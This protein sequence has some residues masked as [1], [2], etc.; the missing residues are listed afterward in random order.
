MVDSIETFNFAQERA[1]H[2][3]KLYEILHDTRQRNVR[4]DWS[5]SFK[6]LMRWPAREEFVRVDG[7]NRQSM[8]IL[9]SELG[10][11]RSDFQHSYVSELLRSSLTSSISAMDLYFHDIIVGYSWTLLSRAEGDVPKE[12]QKIKIP[13]L[14]TK[15]AIKQ[16]KSSPN[17][18]PSLKLKTE[19]QK[20][21]HRD[22]FQSPSGVER[23]FKILGVQDCWGKIALK[24]SL[25]RNEIIANLKA[26]TGRRNQIVHEADMILK[27][28]A[29]RISRREISH[30]EVERYVDFIRKL[31]ESSNE[32]IWDEL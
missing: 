4:G 17:S 12:L 14:V 24:L 27:T 6:D 32:L 11:S 9:R 26:A 2:L 3:L 28:R 19:L 20:V 8:L 22:T 1:E 16:L 23:A 18:R 21:L 31:V 15:R 7:K 5:A 25:P 13:I 29:K 10:I 30:I